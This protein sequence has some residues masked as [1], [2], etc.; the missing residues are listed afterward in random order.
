MSAYGRIPLVGLYVFPCRTML[1][2]QLALAVEDVQVDD[3]MKNLTA[4][5]RVSTTDGAKNVPVFIHYRELLIG[6]VSHNIII[7]VIRQGM[8][9]HG[10]C[11]CLM[12]L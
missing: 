5:V 11:Q 4:V 2:I 6:I 9:Q 8:A 10:E 7:Y 1:K 12:V 3:G